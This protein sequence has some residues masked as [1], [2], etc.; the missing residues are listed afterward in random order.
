MT[1]R[2][3]TLSD[4]TALRLLWEALWR[5][6]N[7]AY[8]TLTPEDTA[9]WTA[10]MAV[11]L[12]RQ[13]AGDLTVGTFLAVVD[14]VPAGFLAARLEERR[15]GQPRR[16]LTTDHLYVVPRFRGRWRGIGPALI[17]AALDYATP[18]GVDMLELVAMA[19][20][21][22]WARHGWTPVATRYATTVADVRR[23]VTRATKEVA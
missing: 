2:P 23:R 5:E 17:A 21:T 22:Q 10:D 13:M 7:F 20:D 14:D 4:L 1:I 12:E 19:G 3:A 18:L 11:K 8:P 9:H 16:I 15:I 6:G